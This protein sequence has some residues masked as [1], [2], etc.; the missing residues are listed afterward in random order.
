LVPVRRSRFRR[1]SLDARHY[2][3]RKHILIVDAV[4][5]IRA[6]NPEAVVVVGPSNTVSPIIAS[7][8]KGRTTCRGS[9]H[10]LVSLEGFVDALV[11]VEGL[12]RA[13]KDLTREALIHAI[14][15]IHDL[16]AGLGPQLKLDY[17]AKDH[18]GIDHAI[19]TVG[20][21][22]PFR[23]RIGRSSRRSSYERTTAAS[24]WSKA[25]YEE[26]TSGPDSTCLNPILS[27]RCLYSAN[28]SG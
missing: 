26:R 15:S 17:S 5:K 14:E 4:D 18:K 3:R 12:T 6:S 25:W 8:R 16:D 21:E 7:S 1:V 9:R 11:L 23:S 20:E 2:L 19:P 10:S 24:A 22:G 28:S 13:G 27:P